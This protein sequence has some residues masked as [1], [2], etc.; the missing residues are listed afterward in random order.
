M[1][2]DQLRGIFVALAAEFARGLAAGEVDGRRGDREHRRGDAGLVH[3]GQRLLDGPVLHQRIAETAG[4]RRGHIG[5][6]RQMMM[7]VDAERLCARPFAPM[8]RPPPDCRRQRQRAGAEHEARAGSAAESD[9]LAG[10]QQKQPRSGGVRKSVIRSLPDFSV[11]CRVW[12]QPSRMAT[13]RVQPAEA[14]SILTGKH[15][16]MKPV[17]GSCSRLCSFSIWQ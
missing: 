5:R 1:I 9:G 2:R 17:D 10:P 6:R 12:P 7:N 13:A 3:V 14:R 16:T 15:D 4:V 8:P 11:C